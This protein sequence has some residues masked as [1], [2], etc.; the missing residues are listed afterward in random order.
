MKSWPEFHNAWKECSSENNSKP[1][2]VFQKF[3]YFS[4]VNQLKKHKLWEWYQNLKILLQK[5]MQ[6]I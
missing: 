3:N 2:S 1:F 4:T 5:E 6:W